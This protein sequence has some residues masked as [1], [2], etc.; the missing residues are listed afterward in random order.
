MS[1]KT[2]IIEEFIEAVNYYRRLASDNYNSRVGDDVDTSPAFK[3][4]REIY[5]KAPIEVKKELLFNV[6]RILTNS[7]SSDERWK[8]WITKLANGVVDSLEQ[9]DGGSDGNI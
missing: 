8:V 9:I 6:L 3:K 2:V 7:S 4:I 1:E 5:K